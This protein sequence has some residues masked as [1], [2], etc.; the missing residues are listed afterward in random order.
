M[1]LAPG[2]EHDV[3]ALQERIRKAKTPAERHKYERKI[4]QII[5]EAK[6]PEMHMLRGKLI[7]AYR[8]GNQ[9]DIQGISD[10]L[11]GRQ[12]G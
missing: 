2:R 11:L 9:A 7:E 12:Y 3:K 4:Q 1:N 10:E 8:T 5:D 6:R